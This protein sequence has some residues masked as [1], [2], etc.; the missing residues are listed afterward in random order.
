MKKKYFFLILTFSCLF[1]FPKVFSDDYYPKDFSN[2]L[3][4][5]DFD[6]SLIENHIKLY[7][8]YV[9][10]TNLVI[11]LLKKT[12][13]SSYVFGALKRRLGW[14]FDG[15]R[16]HEYYFENLSGDGKIDKKSFKIL[17][18]ILEDF[19]SYENWKKEFINT[20]LI[21]GIGWVILYYDQKKQKLFNVWINE[22]DLGH[23][24]GCT[25]LLIMD[26]WEHAYITQ[27]GLD[28]KK[29][30]DIY[31]QN[32]NWKIVNDRFFEGR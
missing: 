8:G 27:F 5:K 30:I 32:I 31:F 9:K 13:S 16:L 2:L 1:V 3:K 4:M 7:E 23:L 19:S 22:H 18:K 12:D 17:D 15:M 20:G 21:R 29:Y 14:E 25:P 10:N 28:R 11:S 24:A 26:V 6:K